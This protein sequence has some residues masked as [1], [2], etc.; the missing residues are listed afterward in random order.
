MI[1]ISGASGGIGRYLMHTFKSKGEKVLGLYN[2]S[3]PEGFNE[4]E[5]YR[6]DI[7]HT[8]ELE[9]FR[10]EFVP[11][12]NRI[13]LINCAGINYNAFAHKADID[14]WK[15]VIDVNLVGT[16]GIIS[17]VLPHMRE[18]QYGRIINLSSVVARSGVPG[19]SAYAASKSAMW[20]M[21]KA[22]A[23]ENAPKGIT[24]NSLNLGYYNIGMIT[25][26]PE[27][28][29]EAIKS[30]IPTGE[31]GDPQNILNAIHFLIHS[32]YINGEAIDM[33]GGLI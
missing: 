24:I 15:Q 9:K 32:D 21:S 23:A 20:G 1:I 2:S 31:F 13:V 4:D 28:M 30:K 19:T 29:Q 5:L 33:N 17:A 16:F 25:A 18:H 7:T 22:I 26:V 3:K 11:A 8:D 27:K 6:I 12:E 10:T 14:A